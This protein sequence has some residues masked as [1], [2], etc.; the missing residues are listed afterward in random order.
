MDIVQSE[1]LTFRRIDEADFDALK[2]MLGD[3]RVMYAWEHTF[4]DEQ[5]YEWI[6]RQK[7]S[8]RR[9]G[10]GYF[11]AVRKS[12]GAVAGQIGLHRFDYGGE[13]AYEVCYMLQYPYF[14]RGY[15]LE[16][17]NAMAAYAFS[18]MGL[19]AVYAQIK[20]N[21]TASVRVAER[22]GFVYQSVFIKHYN[23]KDMPHYL[24]RRER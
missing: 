13:A 10:V 12:D 5:I 19:P 4:S 17:A 7:E 22:A 20:T 2:S 6:A 3:P 18:E 1:R 24:Y 16:G 14:H 11:A 15:A 8:Y 21:N 23:G 9:D